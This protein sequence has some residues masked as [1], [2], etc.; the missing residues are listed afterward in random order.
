MLKN[1]MKA[2]SLGILCILFVGCTSVSFVSM[3]TSTEAAVQQNNEAGVVEPLAVTP[4]FPPMCVPAVTL[5]PAPTPTESGELYTPTPKEKRSMNSFSVLA[6]TTE[7]TF[8]ELVGD[9][10]IYEE[11]AAYPPPDTYS[12]VIDIF[13]QVVIVYER[14]KDGAYTVPVRYMVCSTGASKTP[15]PRG[16]YS[17]GAHKV[18]FG[19][20]VNDGVYGQYW[21]QITGRIYFHSLLYK[22]RNACSYTTS[23]YKRLGTRTSHGCVR[24]LVPDARWVYYHIAP[25]TQ[26]EIRRGSQEDAQTAAIKEQ[27]IR[28]ELPDTRPKLIP[29]K[30]PNTD[31]WNIETYL[32]AYPYTVGRE[33]L[34]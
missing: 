10:G 32:D 29:G 12:I 23:S 18:R 20:F 3:Q 25:G 2:A 1:R 4:S 34:A 16:T 17:S 19:L 11:P 14:D 22:H 28:P 13:H 8:E 9:N 7:M 6:P 15:T 30:V 24:L 27:L 31:N 26:I 5:T 33:S 21:T